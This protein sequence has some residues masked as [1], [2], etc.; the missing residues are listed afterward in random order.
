MRSNSGFIG[1]F[2]VS[3][4]FLILGIV[5]LIILTLACTRA[6]YQNYLIRE[7]IKQMQKNVADIQDK[8]SQ[9]LKLLT[10]V[11]SVDYVEEK[12]RTE[13]NLVKEGEN[14]TVISGASSVPASRQVE[15]NVLSSDKYSNP[16]LWWNYFFKHT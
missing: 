3:R 8:K 1:K 14:V 6:Y 11:K 4:A 13:L 2:F 16:C 9:L 10:S 7:D 12:A 5:V 15:N